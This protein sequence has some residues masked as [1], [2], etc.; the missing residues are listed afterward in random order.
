MNDIILGTKW[1]REHQA[2]LNL[3][4]VATLS[5]R[6]KDRKGKWGKR[7]LSL[8]PEKGT[9]LLNEVENDN[10][11]VYNTKILFNN[12]ASG[13]LIFKND[14]VS[15]IN[16]SFDILNMVDW[17]NGEPSM[18]IFETTMEVPKHLLSNQKIEHIEFMNTC[19]SHL[20]SRASKEKA[21][22]AQ[23]PPSQPAGLAHTSSGQPVGQTSLCSG[24]LAE[25]SS[26]NISPKLDK[27]EMLHSN[28]EN[29]KLF[30]KLP[31]SRIENEVIEQELLKTSKIRC[32]LEQKPTSMSTN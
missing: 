4:K 24:Q 21:G 3:D 18:E 15:P 27:S 16:F 8:E 29:I 2:S 19:D 14:L 6:L 31:N 23:H 11:A 30:K 32:G 28:L 25:S 12:E 9:F 26:G 13:T 7:Q 10:Y 22:K 1:L 17:E 5:L 20:G